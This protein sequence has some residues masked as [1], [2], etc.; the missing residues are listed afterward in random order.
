MQLDISFIELQKMRV[1][2]LTQSQFPDAMV[3]KKFRCL[4][5][6]KR[7]IMIVRGGRR[8]EFG[9]HTYRYLS[10]S[11]FSIHTALSCTTVVFLSQLIK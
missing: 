5:M 9:T 11:I 7:Y 3:S 4:E 10:H 6:A 2:F 8:D 1:I